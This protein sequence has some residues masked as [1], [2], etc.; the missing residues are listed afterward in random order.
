MRAKIAKF[1]YKMRLRKLSH[2]VSPSVYYYCV[3]ADV[4]KA[5]AQACEK[6]VSSINGFAAALQDFKNNEEAAQDE[7][8]GGN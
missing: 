7:T 2:A 5:V 6:A 4:A 1:L 3:G 8:A